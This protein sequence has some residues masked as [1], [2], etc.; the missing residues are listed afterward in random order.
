MGG[1]IGMIVGIEDKKIV[2]DILRKYM[3]S[4][5]ITAYKLNK[6]K[7]ISNK[8]LKK[9]IDNHSGNISLE[10]VEKLF[11]KLNFEY[12][13][14]CI[15]ENI[16]N[17][18]KHNIKK[19]N[20]RKVKTQIID[21]ELLLKLNSDKII[22]EIKN[23]I[24]NN[25]SSIQNRMIHLG[26][27]HEK[28]DYMSKRKVGSFYSDFDTRTLLIT[29]IWELNDTIFD[30]WKEVELLLGIGDTR[31]TKKIKKGLLSVAK[32]LKEIALKLEEAGVDSKNN[33]DDEI[34]IKGE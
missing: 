27:K 4:N 12:K 19:E 1:I 33:I 11:N 31:D 26:T 30:K 32:N 14:K 23:V 16:I 21:I 5:N 25:S 22:N 2:A 20:V 13:D 6:L 10:I 15:I 9:L 8:T 29:K 3:K 34:I 18:Y 28:S 7:I 17:K 24:E